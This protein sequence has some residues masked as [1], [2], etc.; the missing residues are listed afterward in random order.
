MLVRLSC[1]LLLIS[2]AIAA[3]ESLVAQNQALAP[4][5]GLVLHDKTHMG[6]FVFLRWTEPD[7][8]VPEWFI[9]DSWYE[10]VTVLLKG[11]PVLKLTGGGGVRYR[12]DEHSGT[13]INADGVPDL[14]VEKY[15]GGAHC[16]SSTVM[17]AV[18]E[19]AKPYFS[20]ETEHCSGRLKDLDRDSRLEFVTC[21]AAFAY[22][23]CPYVDSP[24][25]E[26]VYSYNATKGTFVPDTP[27]FA[28]YLTDIN[29]EIQDVE[30]ERRKPVEDRAFGACLVLRPV[31][32]TIYRT[33]K[34]D[35][36]LELLRRLYGTDDDFE[37]VKKSIVETI[38]ASRHFAAR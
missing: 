32:D 28:R 34:F 25:P 26:V 33:G 27:R 22:T 7:E 19:M 6:P 10:H 5:A 37:E 23:Y 1:A 36:G 9:K 14:I 3:P 21:D 35:A 17:Y 30:A 18:R 24:K 15:T 11:K 16:C 8:T 13:D 20:V 2:I 31:L 4:A 12:I 29:S 38:R